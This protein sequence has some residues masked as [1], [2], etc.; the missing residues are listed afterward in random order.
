M[1]DSSLIK[2]N[3]FLDHSVTKF[4]IVFFNIIKDRDYSLFIRYSHWFNDFIVRVQYRLTLHRQK[5]YMHQ[6][7]Y[8]ERVILK[9]V[10]RKS[11]M[12]YLFLSSRLHS[13]YVSFGVIRVCTLKILTFTNVALKPISTI[14][15]IIKRYVL[16]VISIIFM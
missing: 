2:I 12:R 5:K 6:L 14:A 7:N 9:D 15:T 10:Y 4:L 11:H 8:D 1:I 16:W 13:D 3:L